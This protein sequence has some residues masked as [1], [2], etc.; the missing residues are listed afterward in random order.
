MMNKRN[1]EIKIEIDFA[2]RGDRRQ[3]SGD[4]PL[5]E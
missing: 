3:V 1:I 2:E 5:F 4:R